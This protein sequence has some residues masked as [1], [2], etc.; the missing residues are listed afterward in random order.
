[1]TVRN[2]T[3]NFGDGWQHQQKY[4]QAKTDRLDVFDGASQPWKAPDTV[5]SEE[6]NNRD[7][8]DTVADRLMCDEKGCGGTDQN[9]NEI[10]S[11]KRRLRYDPAMAG[12]HI[13]SQ[14]NS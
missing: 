11:T 14:G 10:D 13:P 7:R 8:G 4:R 5:T 9:R 12:E 6:Q 3:Q 1:M 2:T